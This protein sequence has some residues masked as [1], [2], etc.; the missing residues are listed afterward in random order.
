M[1]MVAKSK[2]KQQLIP[3]NLLMKQFDLQL[4]RDETGESL[5]MLQNKIKGW[6]R[7]L[8]GQPARFLTW[9]SLADLNPRIKEVALIEKREPDK[10]KKTLLTE[11]RRHYED[12]HNEQGY[13]Q[14]TSGL[15]IWGDESVSPDAL[16]RSARGTFDVPVQRVNT[17]PAF[18]QGQYR[19]QMGNSKCPHA[20]LAPVGRP[21][22]RPFVAIL[23][24]YEFEP[25]VWSFWQP[26]NALMSLKHPMAVCI[27]IPNTYETG[28]ARAK[29]EGNILAQNVHLNTTVGV[30]S[31]TQKK[32]QDCHTTLQAF[33]EGDRLHDVQIVLALMSNSLEGLAQAIENT[34]GAL[35]SHVRLRPEPGEFQLEMVKYFTSIPTQRILRPAK[36]YPCLSRDIALMFGILGFR[37]LDGLRGTLRG[38]AAEGSYPFFY[39]SWPKEKIA[40]HE[41]WAGMT[42]SGKTFYLNTFLTRQYVEEKIPF[43]LIEPMGHGKK[44]AEALNVPCIV[45]SPDWTRIN[46]LDVMFYDR[47]EQVTHVIRLLAAILGRQFTGDSL[48]NNQKSLI[49][50]A[51][52]K[53]YDRIG[54]L[55]SITPDRAPI[56]QDLCGTLAGM[57]ENP[58]FRR[59]AKELADEIAGLCTGDGPYAAF[60]NDRTNV[61]LGITEDGRPRIFSLD[62]MSTD[63]KL[64]AITYTQILSA[65]RRDCLADDSP[66]TVAVDEYYRLQR[67]PSLIDFLI[68][69]AKTFRTRRVKLVVIDQNLSVFTKENSRLL[70]E[71]C[72]IRI[73]FKQQ[74]TRELRGDEAF[75]RY[76]AQHIQLIG[77]MPQG[78]FLLDID[79]YGIF[80]LHNRVS[81]FELRRFAGS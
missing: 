55:N 42:G 46:P 70:L 30:D 22:G 20:H 12:L 37:K 34:V 44:L 78:Y 11:M 60:L 8:E 52:L 28:K 57:G 59:I 58:T 50:Q 35:R 79:N 63:E 17:L 54:P 43:D 51:V 3:T 47:T 64:L 39:N 5:Y 14:A 61:D 76:T 48:G 7:S 27:D 2:G 65:I 1:N 24:S 9:Q 10:F 41:L 21:G 69:G 19:L 71:N 77:T 25:V 62:K 13:L 26:L 56:L 45:P 29:I 72:P 73:I 38:Q 16:A 74:S 31:R 40:T 80:H 67:H 53:L 36:T 33:D 4:L 68:E 75:E 32:V 81:A 15:V 66:R 18:I 23:S 6:L 49:G